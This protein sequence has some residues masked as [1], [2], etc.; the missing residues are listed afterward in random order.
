MTRAEIL[1]NIKNRFSDKNAKFF[2]KSRKRVYIDIERKDLSEFIKCVFTDLGARFNIASAVD[3][4]KAIEI[5]YHFTFDKVNLM[6]SIRAYLDKNDPHIHSIT[7]IVKGSEWIEREMHELLGVEFDGHDD[8]Q[9]LLL[10]E[11]WPKDKH[12]LRRDFKL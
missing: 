10:P 12:P 4:P 11:G 9:P 6:V 3:T 7:S 1:D 8:I 5:L 2:E